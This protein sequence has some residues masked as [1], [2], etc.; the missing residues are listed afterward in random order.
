MDRNMSMASR[1]TRRSPSPSRGG[2][3]GG[4]SKLRM[5]RKPSHVRITDPSHPAGKR[6][7]IDNV[8]RKA[9]AFPNETWDKKLLEAEEKDP[10]RWRHTGFKKMYIEEDASSSD[11][12]AGPNGHLPAD[13][14][15]AAVEVQDQDVAAV[16][17]PVPQ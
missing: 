8:M 3:G 17:D 4:G 14:A 7:E 6:K 13:M 5:D 2:G 10:N 12:D 11:S 15:T 9:R 1:L 16:A